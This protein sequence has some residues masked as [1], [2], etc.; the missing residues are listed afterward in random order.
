VRE[1]TLSVAGGRKT[2]S[3]VDACAAATAE[4]RILVLTYTQTN[5][6]AL[7]ARLAA[8]GLAARVNVMGW[9]SFLMAHWVRPYLPM[10]FPERRLR[11]LNFEGDPGR[12]ATGEARFLDSEYRAYRRHVAHLAHDVCGA[13]G[14]S[15]IDRLSRIYDAIHI[16]EVQDLNGYDLEVLGLLLDAPT[17]LAM[18]GDVRQAVLLTNPRD[19]K[20]KQYK[21]MAILKWFES[22]EQAGRIQIQ[23][24]NQTWRCNQAIADLADSIFAASWG[25][26]ATESMNSR[27]TVH[28]GIFVVGRADAGRYVEKFGPLCLRISANSARGV[29]LPFMNIRVAKGMDVER[30]F[31]WP[32][33]G[34]EGFLRDGTMLE[35][36]PCCDLYVAVTRARS[37]VAFAVKKPEDFRF[38]VWRPSQSPALT[39]RCPPP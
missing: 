3:I 23:H 32:T 37:S 11:G 34:M 1:L 26:P 21:G 27:Q 14:G 10:H 30:V 5:Q 20:N 33:E 7:R 29:D 13:S 36:T 38:P 2:Q 31:I 15:V 18:V 4:R 6:G 28:D 22:Q 8:T 17:D 19:L 9:F 25:F 12:Y 16:D 24:S 39:P 35:G